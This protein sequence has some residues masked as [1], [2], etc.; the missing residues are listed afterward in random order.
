MPEIE[1]QGSDIGQGWFE[2][3]WQIYRFDGWEPVMLSEYGPIVLSNE[4]AGCG[5]RGHDLYN[6]ICKQR[7]VAFSYKD[8]NQ[9]GLLDL[10]RTEE[11][12]TFWFKTGTDEETL[13]ADDTVREQAIDPESRS[14]HLSRQ[15]YLYF[16]HQFI[17][18]DMTLKP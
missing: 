18:R 15:E 8:L 10:I 6:R 7:T 11:E 3:V 5:L 1:G 13:F 2:G 16:P 4:G 12:D 17:E 14:T 9:D